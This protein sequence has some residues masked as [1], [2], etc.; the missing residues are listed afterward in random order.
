MGHPRN[1]RASSIQYSQV[2]QVDSEW[3]PSRPDF[4]FMVP[5]AD[6]GLESYTVNLLVIFTT[7]LNQIGEIL[8][9]WNRSWRC[10]NFE[11]SHALDTDTADRLQLPILVDLVKSIGLVEVELELDYH[12]T[13]LNLQSYGSAR[14]AGWDSSVRGYISRA[15]DSK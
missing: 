8:H 4:G 12:R 10:C 13:G 5:C 11:D 2:N 6:R 14:A 9:R 7:L 1:I 15:I 3:I